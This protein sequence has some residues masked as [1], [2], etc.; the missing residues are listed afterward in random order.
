MSVSTHSKQ[1]GYI[2]FCFQLH[3]SQSN[4][5]SDY[6]HGTDDEWAEAR[7]EEKL[8]RAPPAGFTTQMPLTSCS[9]DFV[10]GESE[11]AGAFFSAATDS[12]GYR[13]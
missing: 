9:V 2:E 5:R 7:I 6:L 13:V 11:L 3:L 4:P 8:N 1:A 10:R 12:D